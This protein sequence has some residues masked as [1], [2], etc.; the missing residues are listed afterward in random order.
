MRLYDSS[1]LPETLQKKVVTIDVQ[2][3][4]ALFHKP[5]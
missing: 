4:Y 3:Q 2:V 5:L 1:A